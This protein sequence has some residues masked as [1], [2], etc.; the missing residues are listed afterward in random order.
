MGTQAQ[1]DFQDN[2]DYPTFYHKMTDLYRRLLEAAPV[3]D[4][5]VP[6]TDE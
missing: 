4:I 5:D 6:S 3:I 2:L 1:K